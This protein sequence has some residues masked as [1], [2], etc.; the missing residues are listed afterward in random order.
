M[1]ETFTGPQSP[2]SVSTSI[3]HDVIFTKHQKPDGSVEYKSSDPSRKI[4]VLDNNSEAPAENI[5]CD[6]EVIADTHPGDPTKGKL[7]ARIISEGGVP[8]EIKKKEKLASLPRPVEIDEEK[9]V[10]YVLDQEVPLR[11]EGGPLVPNPESFRHFTL[12]I[13]TLEILEKIVTAVNLRE[14]CLLEGETSTSKTSSIEYLAMMT[15]YEVE[16]LNL[17]G[18]TD[19]SDLIGKFV[20]NDGRLQI[21]Y[22]EAIRHPELLDEGSLKIIKT[23]HAEGRERTLLEEQ[24]IAAS[25]GLTI[26]G[27]RWQ[28][29]IVPRAMIEGHWCIL[30]ELGL[31]EP[32]IQRRINSVLEKEPE[33]TI[34]EAGEI[35]KI[36]PGG[37][38]VHKDFRLFATTNPAEYA[39]NIG[40]S[41]D[42]RNRWTSNLICK[43]PSEEGY[44]AM[45]NY[46]V[47]GEQ[48]I[49]EIHGQKYR[50][51]S[52]ESK[53]EKLPQIPNLEG[54]LAKLAKFEVKLEEMAR[55]PSIG[56]SR[57]ER[58]CFTRRGL[59]QFIEFL[60]NMSIITD[61][62]TGAKLTVLDDPKE[63]IL[64]AIKH[65]FLDA[66]RDPEDLQKVNDAL[67]AIGISEAQW[68]HKFEAPRPRTPSGSSEPSG[69]SG[70]SESEVE[71]EA[72]E[73]E[74][75]EE[76]TFTDLLGNKV[77]VTGEEERDDYR[78]G[79][80]LELSTPSLATPEERAAKK[81]VVVGFTYDSKVVVQLDDDRVI[82][83][84]PDNMSAL[85][86]IFSTR[87]RPS[88]SKT[89]IGDLLGDSLGE[90]GRPKTTFM[91]V[92]GND[93]EITNVIQ[94]GGY[95]IGDRLKI[96]DNI[97]KSDLILPLREAK[98]FVVV[99]FDDEDRVVVQ[100]DGRDV[101]YN[102]LSQINELYEKISPTKAE[103]KTT[104]ESI[105]GGKIEIT[106]IKELGGY[107]V[108]DRL[109]ARE[110]A[111][112]LVPEIRR[113]KEIVVV[114]FTKDGRVVKQLDGGKVTGASPDDTDS[115]FAI[116][117]P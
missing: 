51:A 114:G 78:V 110:E 15:G 49:F 92:G 23:A 82:R 95:Q 73:D 74:A 46:M 20:P 31:A 39:G 29:G 11:R 17:S 38:P 36:G 67:D 106:D 18:Q 4:I 103:A 79:D 47:Y 63:F 64:R 85:Y 26:Q 2:E 53:L 81:I 115:H 30:D 25:L 116:I 112:L 55:E 6:V 34:T 98:E 84:S 10:V 12:D 40:M 96:R 54:F 24:K 72:S 107:R 41:P 33:L 76:K 83:D 22:E 9:G 52:I 42:F 37:K 99:G 86:R 68:L 13:Q 58:Y 65:R 87:V 66:M 43:P 32:Q 108:G 93:V 97:D 16:R 109:K 62:A 100:L 45:L 1:P 77:I 111:R 101:Q 56:R 90:I 27:W 105:Y 60:E 57:K 117:A 7:I 70:I 104:F 102:Q 44:L 61:R 71:P 89:T 3:Y 48:P 59:I 91:D 5:A 80:R 94:Y 21:E 14:P 113:A 19:C 28:Y 88:E 35:T 8:I 50:G 69:R 75:A